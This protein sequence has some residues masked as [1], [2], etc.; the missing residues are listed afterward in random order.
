LGL[1]L[2]QRAPALLNILVWLR[3]M[4]LIEIDHIRL[5]PPQAG[6]KLAPQRIRL[7]AAA[8]LTLLIPE[9]RTFRK[10]IRAVCAP[11]QRPG[12]DLFRMPQSIDGSRI[13]PVDAQVN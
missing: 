5:Q 12:N 7:Q 1:E 8:D 6:L 11:L 2:R 4:N 10:D 9:A 3:P 13:N